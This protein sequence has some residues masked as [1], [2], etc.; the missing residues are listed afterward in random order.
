V[1]TQEDSSIAFL[2]THAC[3]FNVIGADVVSPAV[4]VRALAFMNTK[5]SASECAPNPN[6]LARFSTP[7]I[8]RDYENAIV[9]SKER[10]T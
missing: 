1:R 2:E 6:W 8:A 3:V 5:R 9:A 10:N 7:V 4:A